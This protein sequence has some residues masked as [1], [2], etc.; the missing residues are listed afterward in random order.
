MSIAAL[1]SAVV[2][3]LAGDPVQ[4]AVVG[5]GV[6]ITPQHLLT[7]AHVVA[8]ALKI[9]PT[10]TQA[11]ETPIY[12]DFCLQSGQP[13]YETRVIQW[14]PVQASPKPGELEDIAILALP[15]PLE[16][17]RPARVTAGDAQRTVQLF[18]FPAYQDGRTTVYKDDGIYLDGVLKGKNARGQVEMHTTIGY[19]NVAGG[20][21]GSPVWDVTTDGVVGIVQMI[22]DY[23]GNIR[24]YMI[25]AETLWNAFAKEVLQYQNPYLSLRPFGEAEQ[26]RFFGRDAEI[27]ELHKLVAEKGLRALVG[28][29][30]SGKSSVVFAGLIPQLKAAGGWAVAAC[31]PKKQPFR[32]LALALLPLRSPTETEPEDKRLARLEQE[33][34][35]GTTELPA[36]L[37]V[38]QAHSRQR[39]LLVVDQFEELYT[40]SDKTVQQQFM[41]CL[42]RLAQSDVDAVVLLTLRADFMNQALAYPPFAEMLNGRTRFIS[43][44][45]TQELQAAIEQPAQQVGLRV[46][47]SLTPQI[48]KDV[49]SEAGRLPLL[50]FALSELFQCQQSG[51]LRLADYLDMGGVEKALA[52]Y[53]ETQ[54]AGFTPAEQAQI[55]RLLVRLVLPGEAQYTRCVVQQSDL[56]AD[57]ANAWGLLQ[58]LAERR[59]IT[60]GQVIAQ[61]TGERLQTVPTDDGTAT[62]EPQLVP[63]N[64]AELVHE[65]LIARWERLQNWVKKDETFRRWEEDL[66]HDLVVYRQTQRKRSAFLTGANLAQAEAMFRTRKQDLSAEE[67]TFI[68][69]SLRHK[70]SQTRIWQGVFVLLAILLGVAG[71]QWRIA[72]TQKRVTE[73][74]KQAAVIARQEADTQKLEAQKQAEEVKKREELIFVRKLESQALLATYHPSTLDGYPMQGLLLAAQALKFNNNPQTLQTL[75]RVLEAKTTLY[76][77]IGTVEPGQTVTLSAN[78]MQVVR[79]E[80]GTTQIVLNSA[81]STPKWTPPQGH[82]SSVY[83]LAFSPDGKQ[84][85]SGSYYGTLILWDVVTGQPIGKPW[86]GHQGTVTSIAFSPDGKQ[87][88][89]GSGDDTLILWDVATGQQ[90][91]TPW[92]GHTEYVSSVDFSPDGKQVVSGSGDKMLILWDVAN[93]PAGR[94]IVAGAYRR[95]DQCGLQSRWKAGGQRQWG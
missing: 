81:T 8:D 4:R 30:G 50:Q 19:G 10:T 44:M 89:S 23:Q 80:T 86:Q 84:V 42:L 31:R 77:Q 73:T 57:L 16:Q 94:K 3:I 90:I 76:E 68:E 65:A 25:P 33:F 6:L 93:R 59:L 61:K 64:T 40:Q 66:K 69:A 43:T 7:C 13:L 34:P 1:E 46:E 58:K 14:H 85:I 88:I 92:Q 47:A 67:Q 37:R 62:T 75:Q 53:A 27:Q 74:E 36:L 70:R 87:V 2:R 32:E 82:Q 38:W 35:T 5:G 41:D 83:S 48:L 78:T 28:V 26:T 51:E 24:A 95:G 45:N 9:Q 52:N 21:S 63:R 29:S 60:T 71:W 56:P 54:F 72:E 39:L 15:K 20:F 49:G 11:P 55:E 91:G 79:D 22:D 12:V 18:G 17:A